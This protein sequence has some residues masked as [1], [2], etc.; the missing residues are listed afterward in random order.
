L[1][2]RLAV[3]ASSRAAFA[4]VAAWACAEA[5]LL[6]VVP[7]I[8]LLPLVAAAPRSAL[9]LTLAVVGGALLGSFILATLIVA[10]A[11][12]VRSVLLALPGVDSAM[13]AMVD[14]DVRERGLATFVA[15]GP[16]VPLKVDTFAWL[17]AGGS[18]LSLAL[19]AAVNRLTRIGP[20]ILVAAVVG[21]FAPAALRRH[22]R[23]AAAAYAIFWAALYAIYWRIV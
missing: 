18:P 2:D 12:F 20:G 21:T 8:V 1:I 17:T 19:G 6:P 23:V 16:G 9:R 10:D 13:L 5:V 7:D 15:F 4:L 11:A 22:E 3:F 14:A